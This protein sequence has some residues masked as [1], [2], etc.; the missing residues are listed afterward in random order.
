MVAAS[1][2]RAD[3]TFAAVLFAPERGLIASAAL[4]GRGHDVAVNPVT[5]ECV[6]F[7][8]RPGTFA[9]AFGIE[10]QRAPRAFASPPG[11]HF[12]GHGVFSPDGRL[13]Y[14][15]ENDVTNATGCLGVWDVGAG[16]RR[17]GEL[18]S[19]GVGP[20]D[21]N[22]LPDGRTLV[23]ANGGIAT[24]P[25]DPRR[26]LNLATM[27]ANLAY[28]DRLTGDLL[29]RHALEAAHQRLSI[30]HLDIAGDGTVVFGCQNKGP[31]HHPHDLIGLHRRGT[32]LRLLAGDRVLH[33]ALNHYVSSVAIDASGS[34]AAVTS[35]RGQSVVFVDIAGRRVIGQQRLRDASGIASG[36]S[37]GRFV[38][39][40]GGGDVALVGPHGRPQRLPQRPW[41]WDNH[42]VAVV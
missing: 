8:R 21:L 14:T 25:D 42:A 34:F 18:A 37:P 4:P 9:V 22:V 1:V 39:T 29:E 27:R 40:G 11:R 2:R 28:I 3:R 35:S 20:H 38:I 19:G 7:A 5:R 13:L 16:Y 17:I 23:V 24:H 33:R 30:R 12:Y 6:A 15:T 26:P 32:K 31:R 41:S 10:R 36:V